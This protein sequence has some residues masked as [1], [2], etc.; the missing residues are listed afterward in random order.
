[1]SL[2]KMVLLL[3]I[4][5][6]LLCPL[7]AIA[8]EEEILIGLIPEMNVFSQMERFKAL[9]DYITE[10]TGI[11]IHFTILSRYGNIINTFEGKKLDGAFF[12]SFTGA[13][14]VAKLDLEPLA[15]P[16]NL[17]GLS[18]YHGLLFVRKD[19]GIRNIKGM[20]GKRMAFVER[21]TTA[22]YLFPIAYLKEHG[23]TK[24]NNF[25]REHYYS[26]SHDAAIYAVLN[27]EADIGAAKNTI[28]NIIKQKQPRID[29]ELLILAESPKVPSNGLCVRKSMPDWMKKKLKET[30]L[31]IDKDKKGQEALKKFYALG[32]IETTASDY[33][34]VFELAEKAG[35]DIKNYEYMN[36]EEENNKK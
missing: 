18:T 3:L 14:A 21:A 17:D 35:I 10:K 2:G 16:V 19:S 4:V 25:F 6:A 34:P 13:M 36:K 15:R 24:I 32:F 26:G 11:K 1:M 12:G 27:R 33:R 29:K 9:G 7:S 23:V 22:G 31:N 30:L 28:Y 20:K 8:Q 5:F